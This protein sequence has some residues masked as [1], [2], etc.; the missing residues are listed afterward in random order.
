[1]TLEEINKI[2]IKAKLC[3]RI[4]DV[5]AYDKDKNLV[6]TQYVELP[7]NRSIWY[8]PDNVYSISSVYSMDSG[9]H[10][11]NTIAKKN[12]SEHKKRIKTG[13][14]Q[15]LIVAGGKSLVI[16]DNMFTERTFGTLDISN[17]NLSNIEDANSM[18][19]WTITKE[20]FISNEMDLTKLN[21]HTNM[22]TNAILKGNIKM[23]ICQYQLEYFFVYMVCNELDIKL[24][25]IEPRERLSP[26]SKIKIGIKEVTGDLDEKLIDALSKVFADTMIVDNER[27]KKG[28]DDI[29]EY[30]QTNLSCKVIVRGK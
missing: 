14:D 7:D 6:E 13:D 1:M 5:Y 16:V 23:T 27:I 11:T 20:R 25:I 9:S 29:H 4:I 12:D 8:I 19:H 18:F 26:F 2:I 22:F 24:K 17:L 15:T 30:K 3:N 10:L 28:I 21:R